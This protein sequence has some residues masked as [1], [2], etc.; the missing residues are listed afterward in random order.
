MA[1]FPNS[2]KS[3]TNP[4]SFDRTNSE[5]IPKHSQQH[6]DANDEIAAIEAF[7][8]NGTGPSGGARWRFK[9]VGGILELHAKDTS[10]GGTPWHNV[11]LESVDDVWTLVID[12]TGQA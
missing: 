11:Y 8:L 4:T 10:G 12:P 1:S 6:S 3:F 7:L 5:S 2:V 9:I